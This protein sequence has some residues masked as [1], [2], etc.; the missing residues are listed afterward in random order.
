MTCDVR[1]ASVKGKVLMVRG[2]IGARVAKGQAF[3]ARAVTIGGLFSEAKR[4][5]LSLMFFFSIESQK[6]RSA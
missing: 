6:W 4:T 5:S 2:E 1:Q 3:V